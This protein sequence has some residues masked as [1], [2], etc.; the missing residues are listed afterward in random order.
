MSS[1]QPFTAVRAHRGFSNL[2]TLAE[3]TWPE[4]SHGRQLSEI[5]LGVALEEVF[6]MRWLERK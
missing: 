2:L 4:R 5:E 3:C 1:L 6:S